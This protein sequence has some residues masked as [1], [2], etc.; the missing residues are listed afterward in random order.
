[1]LDIHNTAVII[2]IALFLSEIFVHVVNILWLAYYSG[3]DVM[4]A[5]ESKSSTQDHRLQSSLIQIP[6]NTKY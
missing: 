1:M 6:G 5:S 4:S 2:N 3:N